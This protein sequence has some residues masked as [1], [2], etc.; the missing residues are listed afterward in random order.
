MGQM[1]TMTNKK[2]KRK[3][4]HRFL[5]DGPTKKRKQNKT[6][7]TTIRGKIL[8]KKKNFWKKREKD[9]V[10][11]PPKPTNKFLFF[12]SH[13]D[14]VA[15]KILSKYLFS[16][17]EIFKYRAPNPISIACFIKDL[18]AAALNRKKNHL[19]KTF[20]SIYL[21]FFSLSHT[22]SLVKRIL[23]NLVVMVYYCYYYVKL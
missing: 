23:N 10:T 22:Q 15:K 6:I 20:N 16:I 12:Y 4:G 17:F 8:E 3:K 13:F 7:N 19:K 5:D 14:D 9:K 11:H 18:G 21:H 2:Q 1:E